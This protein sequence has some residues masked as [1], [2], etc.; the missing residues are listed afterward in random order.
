M[1]ETLTE[2]L[3]IFIKIVCALV[4]FLAL[5]LYLTWLERK[6]SALIQDRVG[7]NRA[8]I[9]GIRIIGLFQ[10]FADAIKMIFKEDFV[11]SFSRKF[12]HTIAPFISFF[13][14]AITIAAVPF[15]DILRIGDRTINLQILDFNVGLLFILA[16]LSLGIYGIIISGWASNNRYT[17][18]G[19]LRGAAQVISYEV[20]LGLS[21]IGLIMVYPSLRLS[22]I[23]LYQGEL[24]FGFLPKWGIF[25]Q[26]LGFV[27]FLFAALAET[28][29]VPF[30]L[31]EGESEIIGFFTEY[32]G[33]KWGLFMMTDFMEIIIV[34]TLLTTLFFGGW[35]VPWL[36]S[37]GFHFPWGGELM[38]PHVVVVLFQVAAFNIKVFF[39]CWLQ[40]LIR[41]TYPRFRY[42]QVMDLGWK[43]LVPLSLVNIIG[44]GII[45]SI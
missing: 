13:F 39:F 9:F 5:T 19:G 2:M 20:A 17:L 35:Q 14:V 33:L 34:S 43:L 25:L 18:T 28:K 26:P 41:W 15:G 4:W 6:E 10:P 21:L 32:S 12:L 22:S 31:P 30:D 36:A 38:L 16:M 37:D 1:T 23:V 24:L 11:P 40:I 45:M 3:I 42:D 8:S 7:A 44:T 29:R 27:I